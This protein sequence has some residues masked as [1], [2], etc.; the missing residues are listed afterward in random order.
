[1]FYDKTQDITFRSVKGLHFMIQI[2]NDEAIQRYSF[3]DDCN[4]IQ[5]AVS[6][7]TAVLSD[8]LTLPYPSLLLLHK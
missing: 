4:G 7:N 1:M 5:V 2:I 8:F 3:R 6:D